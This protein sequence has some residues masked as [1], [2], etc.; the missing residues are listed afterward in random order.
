MYCIYRLISG[1]RF[2]AQ[3][4]RVFTYYRPISESGKITFNYHARALKWHHSIFAFFFFTQIVVHI[5][6][7]RQSALF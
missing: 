6:F 4:M 3:K 2:L 7:N 1:G 5:V